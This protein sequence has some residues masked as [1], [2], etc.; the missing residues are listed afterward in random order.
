MR[1]SI[2]DLWSKIKSYG[3]NHM[4][5]SRSAWDRHMAWPYVPAYL[6]LPFE[7]SY[8]EYYI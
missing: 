8:T 3:I 2:S 5:I 1:N 4:T 6:Y 7:I